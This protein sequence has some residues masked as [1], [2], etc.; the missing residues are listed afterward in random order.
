MELAAELMGA[1]AGQPLPIVRIATQEAGDHSFP[2][3]LERVCN[4]SLCCAS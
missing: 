2:T 3:L 1:A 4:L